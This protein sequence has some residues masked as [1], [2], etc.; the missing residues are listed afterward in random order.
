MKTY[1][2]AREV[3]YDVKLPDAPYRY[4][5]YDNVDDRYKFTKKN[6]ELRTFL[7]EVLFNNPNCTIFE[8]PNDKPM[9][10]DIPSMSTGG[11]RKKGSKNTR[12]RKTKMR[13]SLRRKNIRK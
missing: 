7:S 1:E 11:R 10:A 6:G 13:Y 3:Y 12:K 4:L 9:A 2:E 5:R 8:L